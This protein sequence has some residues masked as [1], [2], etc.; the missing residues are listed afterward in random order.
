MQRAPWLLV[1]LWM[2]LPMNVDAGTK[3]GSLTLHQA[4]TDVRV[5]HLV[6][7]VVR[8]DYAEADRQRKDGADVNVIG[9]DGISPLL[10][11]IFENH[12]AHNYRGTE[13]L[14]KAGAN[15][16][17]RDAK[18][19]Y[20]AMYFAAGGDN[21]ELLELLLQ[22]KGDPNLLGPYNEP[23]LHMAVM[24]ERQKAI[25][26]LVKYGVNVNVLRDGRTVAQKAAALGRFDLIAYFLEKG[27]NHNLQGLAVTV[28]NRLVPP[29][30]EEQRWKDKVIEMLKERGV[31]FPAVVQRKVPKL[32][33]P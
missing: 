17:Y 21:P 14:L 31:K 5:A 9:T 32:D 16:N 13:Y 6:D 20:S 22:H 18:D 27:L 33:L 30:S 4:F 8:G 23:L 2:V 10:W 26:L 28:E 29:N 3:I 11:V 15:P 7:A 24:D 1:T 19:G 25:E 12:R